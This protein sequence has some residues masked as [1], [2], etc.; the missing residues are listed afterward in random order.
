MATFVE[1]DWSS[2]DS[3]ALRNFLASKTGKRLLSQLVALCP[4]PSPDDEN[5]ST[6]FARS[7]S[8]AGY[9][10]CMESFV[11]LSQPVEEPAEEPQNGGDYRDLDDDSQWSH[12]TETTPS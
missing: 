7:R 12:L 1:A 8:I 6:S 9:Q 3:I 10:R 2:D 11:S 5:P 4:Q